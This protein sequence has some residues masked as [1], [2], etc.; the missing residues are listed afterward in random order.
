MEQKGQVSAIQSNSLFN[1]HV[2]NIN[3]LS[4]KISSLFLLCTR[5]SYI[6]CKASPPLT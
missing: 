1:V 6:V 2:N 4:A 5:W 3:E